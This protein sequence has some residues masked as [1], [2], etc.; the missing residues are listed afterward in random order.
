MP[1]V[2]LP[3]DPDFAQLKKQARDLQRAVRAAAPE[4][5]ALVAE[6]D[7]RGAPDDAV[8]ATYALG[9]A[10]LVL[11]RHYGF[12]SWARLKAHL[13]VVSRYSRAPSRVTVAGEPADEFLRLACLT[14]E[15]DGPERWEQARRLLT[16][17]PEIARASIHTAAT[18]ADRVHV[19]R[20]VDSDPALARREGGPYSWEPLF[21]LAYAR[22][23]PD[24]D[25]TAVLDTATAL[26]DHGADPNAGYLWHGL[27][28]PFTVLTGVFGEGEAGPRRQ[29]RHP[30]SQAFARLLLDAGADANDGQALYNRMFE[31]GNDHLELLFEY[32]LGTGDGGRGARGSAT[33]STHPPS[34]CSGNSSGRSFTTWP[35]VWS[36][37]SI[38]VPT[39][40]RA[41][42]TVARRARRRR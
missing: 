42:P 31:P 36:C 9:A 11:A 6:H 32:G 18:V 17:H 33:R 37:S 23:D 16:D 26:L 8:R 38:T 39:F 2:P 14:Y 19:R 1:T 4:A 35:R 28:T 30:H 29:P 7:P 12:T 25:A 27:P 41:F 34:W 40:T 10:Q 21:S 20:L 3:A 22:H 13:E 5:V 24:V 15:N